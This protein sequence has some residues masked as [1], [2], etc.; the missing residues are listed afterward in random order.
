[1]S[2]RNKFFIQFQHS[3]IQVGYHLGTFD[4][5]CPDVL[6]RIPFKFI[7]DLVFQAGPEIHCHR[8]DLYLHL[9]IH[10]PVRQVHRHCHDHMIA[11]IAAGFRK[12]DIVLHRDHPDIPLLADHIRNPVYVGRKRADNPYPRNIV[13]V[14]DHIVNGRF[15]P[16][17]L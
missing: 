3:G 2:N 10:R 17:P 14:F 7:V 6:R 16:V 5:L 11:F 8:P 9:G 4:Q 12:G 1:M 15:M 13:Y